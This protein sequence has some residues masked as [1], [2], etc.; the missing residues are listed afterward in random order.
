MA[1]IRELARLTDAQ[2]DRLADV[3]IAVVDDG[4]SIGFLP[5]L[6]RAEATSYWRGVLDPGVILLV[7]EQA[8]RIVGTVQLQLALRANGRHRA[9]VAKLMVD[10][11]ARRL[12]IGRQLMQAIGPIARREGRTLLVLDTR[13]GDPSNALYLS[14]GYQEAGRIPRYARW[15]NGHLDRTVLYFRELRAEIVRVIGATV[16]AVRTR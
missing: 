6:P 8:G 1:D 9:E 11:S 13:E 7:A 10:P 15:A 16:T 2:I 3:L 14:M 12:G 4:A 5:P